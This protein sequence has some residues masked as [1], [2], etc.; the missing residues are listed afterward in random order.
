MPLQTAKSDR[1]EQGDPCTVKVC[2]VCTGEMEI[3]Y[4]RYH[5][6]VCVCVDCHAAITVPGSAWEVARI[7]RET[8]EAAK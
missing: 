6:K 3:A 4:D 1:D 2:P 8:R 7:K 5:Q